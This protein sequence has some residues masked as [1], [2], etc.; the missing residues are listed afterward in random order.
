MYLKLYKIHSVTH[1]G[2][3][4]MLIVKGKDKGVVLSTKCVSDVCD[5]RTKCDGCPGGVRWAFRGSLRAVSRPPR[6]P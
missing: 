2:N 1:Y 6:S 3:E 4:Y 5:S